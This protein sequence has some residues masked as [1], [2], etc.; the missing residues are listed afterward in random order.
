[1]AI[2]KKNVNYVDTGDIKQSGKYLFD[3]EDGTPEV[4]LVVF[5]KI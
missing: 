3:A 5:R 2:I 4:E 1:M